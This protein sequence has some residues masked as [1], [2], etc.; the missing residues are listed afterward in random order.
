VLDNAAMT[1][2]V[3]AL[4]PA[5]PG[6][7]VLV[8]SRRPL[9]SLDADARLRVGVLDQ[10]DGL[11][12]L[13]ELT[14]GRSVEPEAAR[15]VVELSGGLPLAIRVAAGRLASRPDL[16]ATTYVE[17]LASR[18]LD[19]LELG[20]LAVRACIRTSYDALL[21]EGTEVD[22]LA[23][24]AFRMLGLLHVPNVT[25]WVVAAM[26]GVPG[27]EV[28]RA[29]L[30]RLVDV[31]LVEPVSDDR[32]QLHDLVRLLAAERAESEDPPPGREAAVV[33]AISYYTNAL[34]RAEGTL[35]PNKTQPFGDP[36][37]LAE[38]FLPRFATSTDAKAWIEGE[39]GN[40]MP[41]AEQASALANPARQ[42]ILWFAFE[43]WN[44]LDVRCEWQIAYRLSRLVLD[45]AEDGGDEEGV[46]CGHLLLGRSAACFG[47]YD[48][49][50]DHLERALEIWR[51]LK[52]LRGI[53]LSLIGRGVV[54]ARRGNPAAALSNY[55]A[56]LD[57]ALQLSLRATEASA[58][59]NMSACYAVMGE[60]DRAVV[61]AERS[62]AASGAERSLVQMG[63]ALNNL[64]AA[65]CLRG[66]LT[67]A[68]RFADEAVAVGRQAG[69]RLRECEGLIIRSLVHWKQSRYDDARADVDI[70]IHLAHANGYRYA[71]AAALRLHAAIIAETG[72]A[73]EATRT[74]SL[75]EE[76]SARLDGVWRDP[77]LELLVGRI[78]ASA[79]HP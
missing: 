15:S 1:R 39:L 8:T 35:R 46:A 12:L 67:E 42:L 55:T 43:L 31:Q 45:T 48:A 72:S 10:A 54:E 78:G 66:E 17:R 14:R 47:D 59:L 28:A 40:L 58:L 20:D 77:I 19:E 6:C 18:R 36:P 57:L 49:A 5:A 4:V 30:D 34:W 13:G 75:A 51:A 9:S 41:A 29:A 76:A 56:A 71:M 68:L 52:N 44:S 69:D 22:W 11:A 79:P 38:V 32:Y 2:Q 60:L 7:A 16:P 21:S 23:A 64:A 50:K 70:A 74:R 37:F 27:P 63:A 62:V 26:L 33:R 73:D 24:R 61:A 65:H 25:S 53:A 3:A